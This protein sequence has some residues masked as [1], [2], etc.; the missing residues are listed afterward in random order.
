MEEKYC[1]FF[2]Q[3]VVK[4]IGIKNIKAL[5]KDIVIEEATNTN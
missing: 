5:S 4:P 3:G 2:F 1:R